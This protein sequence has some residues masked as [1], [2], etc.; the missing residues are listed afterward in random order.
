VFRSDFRCCLLVEVCKLIMLNFPLPYA[1]ELIYSVIARAGVHMGV[2]SPKQ[3]LDAVFASR[4]VIATVDLPNHLDRLRS[5]YPPGLRYS[6]E[7]LAYEHTLFP[8]YAPF[9]IESRRKQCLKNMAANSRGSIHLMLGVAASRLKQSKYLRYCPLC[10][11]RQLAE[12]GEYYWQRQ[13]Q[14]V[15]ADCC[16]DHG[17]LIEA[18]INRHEHHR[19]QFFPASPSICPISSQYSVVPSAIKV[20]RQVERLLH[21]HNKSAATFVQWSHYYHQLAGIAD[22]LAGRQVRHDVVRERVLMHW[23]A[24]WLKTHGL[25]ISETETN[26]LRAIFRKHRNAF[27]YLEHIVALDSLM[28]DNWKID[29]VL[30]EVVSIRSG[31]CLLVTGAPISDGNL[32]EKLS[33]KRAQWLAAIN[34]ENI[35]RARSKN[36][37][38]YA[39]LYRHDRAWLLSV[40]SELY[41]PSIRLTHRVDWQ[42]RDFRICRQLIKIRNAYK[43]LLE[44]PRQSRNWYLT[45]LDHSAMVEKNIRKLP[46]TM[47]FFNR[48]CENVTDYQ[49]RRLNFSLRCLGAEHQQRW[50]LLRSAGLSEERLTQAARS[51]LKEILGH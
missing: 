17:Q 39:W 50:R 5:L 44:S 4:L 35:K 22:C 33:D 47:L 12:Y 28:P 49:I 31:I 21:H 27:S 3:L 24:Y 7:R 42:R 30:A 14:I 6:V 18:S 9:T 26:W 46:L 15:G 36:G 41:L 32:N 11:E 40:N 23:P 10:L 20:A 2:S 38:L 51:R 37:A 43:S 13:W 48:Y 25:A 29:D 16:L 34:Q 8:V 19:H 1:D 45:K